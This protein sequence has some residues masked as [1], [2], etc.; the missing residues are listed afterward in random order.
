LIL[1]AY[2]FSFT[3]P[4]V[5]QELRL[6]F[7]FFQILD[8]GLLTVEKKGKKNIFNGRILEIEGLPDL[9]LGGY[10]LREFPERL[11]AW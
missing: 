6:F 7:N 2:V 9:K 4:D 8:Q 10:L 5:F 1:I 3:T 11:D